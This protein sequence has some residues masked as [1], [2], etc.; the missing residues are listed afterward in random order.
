MRL[1]VLGSMVGALVGLV[2]LEAR[3]EQYNV[4]VTAGNEGDSHGG[5][6]SDPNAFALFQ[7]EDGAG[8]EFYEASADASAGSVY[9]SASHVD[10]LPPAAVSTSAAATIA[11]TLHFD[12]LPADSVTIRAGLNVLVSATRIVGFA[13]AAASIQIG[14][15]SAGIGHN[16]VTGPTQSSNCPGTGPGTIEMVLTRDQIIA[17]NAELD[18]AVNV[19]ASLEAQGGLNATALAGGALPLLA[20]GADPPPG[21][22]YLE[23]DPPLQISYTGPNTF[24]PVPEAGAPLLAAVVAATLAACRRRAVRART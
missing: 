6:N 21:N 19:S 17:M 12:E 9:A 10:P 1:W 8:A 2:P 11:E 24:F 14:S 13:N 15:C 22:A 3:A 20:R 23:L 18:I 5:D 16:A 4:A 7:R